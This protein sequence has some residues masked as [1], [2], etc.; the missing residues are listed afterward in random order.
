MYVTT[1]SVF[2]YLRFWTLAKLRPLRRFMHPLCRGTGANESW[3]GLI[4][5]AAR[6][7][8]ALAAEIAE[9]A[10]LIKGY[11]STHKRGSQNF[12]MIEERVILP[13]LKGQ[14]GVQ[15]AIDGIASAR[16]AALL[17]PEGTGLSK[18]LDELDAGSPSASQ[19]NNPHTPIAIVRVRGS[20]TAIP[21]RPRESGDP[22]MRLDSRL[23][24][25]ERPRV[26][27]AWRRE[28]PANSK[29]R[30]PPSRPRFS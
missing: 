9:C 22:K 24:G 1:T 13:A 12:Q 6:L 26:Q 14:I 25:N 20:A 11:G 23:R 21:A 7:S 16:T 17:D 10:R 27:G 2:G 3:L 8:P 18:C 4:A 29:A 15:D 5:R 28:C 30:T 19:R